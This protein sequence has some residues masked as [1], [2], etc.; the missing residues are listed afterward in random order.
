[1]SSNASFF[2]MPSI[3]EQWNK[4][5]VPAYEDVVLKI[6]HYN[7]AAIIPAINRYMIDAYFFIHKVMQMNLDSQY[8]LEVAKE[9]E[10]DM[11]KFKCSF[12]KKLGEAS[13]K[14]NGNY[15]H[16]LEEQINAVKEVYSNS[17]LNI[18]KS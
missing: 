5:I 2:K 11:N 8:I 16:Q 13:W 10:E 18:I 14:P 3:N 6:E 9:V 17:P 4:V 15:Y 1:M 12:I 7:A